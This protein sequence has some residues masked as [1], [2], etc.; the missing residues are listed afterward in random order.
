MWYGR[1]HNIV[2]YSFAIDDSTTDGLSSVKAKASSAGPNRTR[3]S[4][5]VQT[6]FYFEAV[7]TEQ[8]ALRST[9]AA[10]AAPALVSG[11]LCVGA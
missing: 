7:R 1:G 5:D 8:V 10:H 4:R 6:C 11:Q 9:S 2:G 3:R